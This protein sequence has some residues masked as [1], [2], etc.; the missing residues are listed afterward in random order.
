MQVTRGKG[1]AQVVTVNTD[2]KSVSGI[3]A[4]VAGVRITGRDSKGQR[5]EVY[6]D[7]SE[8]AVVAAAEAERQAGFAGAVAQQTEYVKNLEAIA[9]AVAR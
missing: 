2:S 5:I 4:M 3:E 9:K 6:L 1:T 7:D 8:A